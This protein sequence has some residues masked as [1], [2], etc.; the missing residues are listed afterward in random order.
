MGA[1]SVAQTLGGYL[2]AQRCSQGDG[3][4]GSEGIGG[5]RGVVISRETRDNRTVHQG[6]SS[7][8][9]HVLEARPCPD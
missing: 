7:R 3:R 9:I 1:T 8:R 4:S 5:S 2:A 6:A